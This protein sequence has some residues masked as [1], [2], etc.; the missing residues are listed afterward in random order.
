[1]GIHRTLIGSEVVIDSNKVSLGSLFFDLETLNNIE[2]NLLKVSKD[3]EQKLKNFEKLRTVGKGAFG[4]AILY[5][6]KDDGLMVIIKVWDFL[7]LIH[8]ITINIFF[9]QE[10]N[11]LD[12]SATE[13][14][15]ALN[16]VRVLA[17][18]DHPNIVTYYDSFERDGVLMIEMEY[19]D[20]GNLAESL[21]KKT[22]R[23]E[24]K[25][26]VNIFS[27]IVSAIRHMHDNNVLHRDLK[28]A[29]IF[30]TKENMVKVGDFGISKVQAGV[31]FIDI[32]VFNV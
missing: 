1:M 32:E 22:V 27:Q 28:T 8:C 17:T 13:R 24:E 11:M 4:A 9:V 5:R 6:K 2:E 21:A 26:I 20:G 25:D 30:L 12:L 10:I 29:N 23:M 7:T 31:Y 18:L 19:A 3:K 16:E 15:M 14:Q